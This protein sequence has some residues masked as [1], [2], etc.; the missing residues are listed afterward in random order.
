MAGHPMNAPAPPIWKLAGVSPAAIALEDHRRQVRFGELEERTNAIGHGLGA[1]G[2]QPG[3]HVALVASNRAE[4]IEAL[5]GAT[6]AGMLVTPVKT[7]WTAAEI[8]YLLRDAG[9]RAVVTDVDTAR[10]AAAAAGIPAIDLERGVDGA[11]FERWLATQ[12]TRP[13]PRER[14]G[15]RLS[16]TSGT[17]GRPKGVHR[18]ADSRLPWCEAFVASRSIAATA[19]LPVDGPHLNVSALFHGA[20]LAYSL[21]LLANGCT[22]R[23]A[24]RWDAG[25]ALEALGRD[26]R[27]TCM[28][29]TMFRQ[30][31]ALPAERRRAFRAP[32]LGAVLHGGEPCP[33]PVKRQMME[34]LGPILVEYYGMTEGGLT[35][36]TA[37]D[38]LARPGTVGRPALGMQVLVLGPDGQRLKPGAQ[39][40][41]YFLPPSGKLFEYRREPEKT[42]AAHTRD[43]AFTVGDIGY[44]DADG[45]LFI[46]GRTADVIVSGGVNVYPA[47]IEEALAAQPG[48]RDLCVVGGPDDVRGETPV[49][50]V[51]LEPD[52][53]R[54][55]AAEQA[56]LDALAAACEARLAGYLRPRRLVVRDVLPR[57]PT[58]K[59]LRHVLRAELWEG[60]KSNFAAPTR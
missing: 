11:G 7:S 30:L 6:R 40:T 37:A 18:F 35:I 4:F 52:A 32:A 42:A 54:D 43:G 56:T 46:A 28:V 34:W 9:S 25:A 2:V 41:I 21:S 60:H 12:A 13:L 23:I 44:V 51:V 3:D 49:A 5:L 24:R 1:L 26:V 33:Q 50:F 59:L 15:W 36:A 20:P 31:L 17:T 38:W 19:H 8:E 48:V 22:M 14:T 16:Y 45:Y 57:D 55:P 27:S 39:G 10:A 29:P 58:G 53:C 47:E